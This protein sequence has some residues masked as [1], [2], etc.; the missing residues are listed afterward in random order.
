MGRFAAAA[1]AVAALVAT[2][3]SSDDAPPDVDLTQL[4]ADCDPGGGCAAGLTCLT[5]TGLGGQELHSCEI[6]C[7]ED[8]GACPA[9]SSC[10]TIS[11]GPGAVCRA[12]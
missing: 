10:V 11:D 6:G 12:N 1:V 7:G 9:G 4:G 8:P 3:C 2:A 5:Y